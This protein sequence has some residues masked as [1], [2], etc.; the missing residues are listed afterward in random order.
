VSALPV[1]KLSVVKIFLD[2]FAK[3]CYLIK[4][5]VKE[6][7]IMGPMS[8]EE[9][10]RHLGVTR[11]NVSNT[12]K[13]AMR[14]FYHKVSELDKSWSPFQIAT[15]MVQ[16]FGVTAPNDIKKMFNLFPPDIRG[17]IEED[18]KRFIR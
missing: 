7:K 11:Q 4:K 18:A 9:I 16:M 12:L 10:A 1:K 15:V 2:F 5:I 8:G 14:K 3:I 6:V 13:R 17:K